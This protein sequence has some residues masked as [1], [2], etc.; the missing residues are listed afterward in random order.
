MK[1][2]LL[3]FGL[4]LLLA[5]AANA[6]P[7]DV[8]YIEGDVTTRMGSGK[9]QDTSIGDVLNTGDSLKT[10][11][12]GQ[13]ELDQKGVTIK[14]SHGTVF[15]LME[16]SQAGKTASVMSVALGSI[17]FRYDKLTGS[18]PQ[19]RTNGAVAGVRGTE[20][21]VFAGADGSTLFA[22]DSGQVTVESEGKS[23]ELAAAEGVEV[24]LGQPPGDKFVVHS[25]QIDYSKWNGDKLASMMSDPI[26]ALQNIQ[27]TMAGY[28]KDATDY[29]TLLKDYREKLSTEQKNLLGIRTEKGQA[30]GDKYASEVV[31]PLLV[32]TINLGI[33]VRFSA[34]AALSLRRFVGGRLYVLMKEKYIT[35]MED[36]GYKEFLTE[37]DS[38]LSTF[39]QSIVPYL[40]QADI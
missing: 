1:K 19:V 26:A 10:G 36:A 15:T 22:V 23:V 16:K 24:P 17:K 37:F 12:D 3:S 33:N 11:K 40:V 30:E 34:L 7:S 31:T 28:I 27:T 8:T 25:D 32:Q 4:A 21:S 18:E 20:F 14:V 5:G 13:A 2:T 29:Y 6:V 9:Q 39:E 38:L 35:Q